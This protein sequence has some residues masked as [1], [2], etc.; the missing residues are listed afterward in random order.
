M[1]YIC[2]IVICNGKYIFGLHPRF[3]HWALETLGIA[4]S[5]KGIFCYVNGH[6]DWAGCLENQSIVWL[7]V[8]TGLELS[9]PPSDLPEG[10]R[11]WMLNQSPVT[12]DFFN[13]ACVIK[14]PITPQRMGFWELLGWWTRGDLGRVVR[15]EHGSC[16]PFPHSLA[17]ASPIWLFLSY[18]FL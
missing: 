3:W 11:G 16:G 2:D 14:P 17:Y 5:Y 1:V 9:V 6:L 15:S 10:D 7:H 4:Q 18:I 13:H 8:T 12:S